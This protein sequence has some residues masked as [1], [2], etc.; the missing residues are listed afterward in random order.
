M[1]LGAILLL[2]ACS[3]PRGTAAT[4]LAPSIPHERR[5]AHVLAL[6]ASLL[7]LFALVL[8]VIGSDPDRLSGSCGR[9]SA[10]ARAGATGSRRASASLV[11][12][13]CG[14]GL[15]RRSLGVVAGRPVPARARRPTAARSASFG[16]WSRRRSRPRA[17]AQRLRPVHLAPGHAPRGRDDPRRRRDQGASGDLRHR[18]RR[19]AS[20]RSRSSA[21]RR[22][23]PRPT[24]TTTAATTTHDDHD[25]RDRDA[26][27][28]TRRRSRRPRSRSSCR[29]SRGPGRLAGARGQH[30]GR[31]HQ[32]RRRL[33]AG[34]RQATARR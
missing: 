11:A 33:L 7:R 31:R 9:S 6:L 25:D 16:T 21:T 26:E 30:D 32:V 34:H 15:R 10:K 4:R 22:P 17:R 24:P 1:S 23:T 3:R 13:R 20:P 19:R 2:P 14:C 28:R 8:P 12:G 5:T 27:L 29:R 18:R